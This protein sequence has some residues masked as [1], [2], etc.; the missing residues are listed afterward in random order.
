[1]ALPLTDGPFHPNDSGNRRGVIPASPLQSQQLAQRAQISP[2]STKHKRSRNQMMNGT[3]SLNINDVQNSPSQ[4]VSP[5]QNR[6]DDKH[7]YKGKG[8]VFPAYQQPQMAAQPHYAGNVFISVE[9]GN[10]NNPYPPQPQIQHVRR[11]L[12]YIDAPSKR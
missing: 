6:H 12:A 1:M 8:V 3:Q 2:H 11:S 4:Q 5:S 7:R 9:V 10:K